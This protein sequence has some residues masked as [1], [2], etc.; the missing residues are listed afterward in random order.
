MNH[1]D[2]G[3]GWAERGPFDG[4]LAAA[5]PE[6]IPQ[7]LLHQLAPGGRL[8][9]PVGGE[10]QQLHVVDRTHEGFETTGGRSGLL[11]PAAPRNG[12]IILNHFGIFFA[13]HADGSCG[14]CSR[15]LRWHYGVYH[16]HL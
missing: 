15:C 16:R 14:H 8:V 9:I 10:T 1:A 11:C 13:W 5:A 4:I 12:E 6:S 3:M 7:E 2:G